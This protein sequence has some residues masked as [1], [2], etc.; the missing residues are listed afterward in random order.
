MPTPARGADGAQRQ[1]GVGR[2]EVGRAD[3]GAAVPADEQRLGRTGRRRPVRDVDQRRA[4]VDLHHAGV[5]D[6]ARDGD[7][8]RA[9]V[10]DQPVGR[11]RHPGRCGRSSPHGP[12]SRRC[13]RAPPVR[14]MRR[15]VTFVGAED[16]S[17]GPSPTQRTSADSSPATKRSG[18]R[19]RTSGTG[20]CT[21]G[22]GARPSRAHGA[23][24]PGG[25]LRARR[26]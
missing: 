22:P 23:R 13:A 14:P 3:P 1:R 5:L 24:R 20:A 19:T 16:G 11:E 25:A 6:R 21:P 12:A 9:R 8:G 2:G 17:D 26:P 10:L 7:E 15:A 4:P 18:G